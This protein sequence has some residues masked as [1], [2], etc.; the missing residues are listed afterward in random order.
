GPLAG[1]AATYGADRSE[2][3][4]FFQHA[5]VST[6]CLCP[7]VFGFP[8]EVWMA[9]TFFW[10]ALALCH[11]TRRSLVGSAS[12][13]AGLLALVFTHECALLL[14]VA[15]LATLAL[16]GVR[17][18]LFLRAVGI[19]LFILPLW[20]A[21]KVVLPPDPYIAEILDQLALT[22]F[23]ADILTDGLVL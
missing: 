3:R 6:A 15:I 5:C 13:V 12:I 20:I 17:D 19:F 4:V 9:H 18:A 7:L 23:D 1:L 21:V 2:G 14:V 16:R 11:G 22:F 8:T 10:P